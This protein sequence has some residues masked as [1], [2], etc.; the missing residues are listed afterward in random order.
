MDFSQLSLFQPVTRINSGG[1]EY[2]VLEATEAYTRFKHP[3]YSYI[4]TWTNAK[5][6]S[7]MAACKLDY[8]A[9]KK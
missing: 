6:A 7:Y 8:E 1:T 4:Y 9:T 5:A 3:D 2:E